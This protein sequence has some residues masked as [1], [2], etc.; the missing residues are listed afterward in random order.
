MNTLCSVFTKKTK[1]LLTSENNKIHFI[2]LNPPLLPQL[3]FLYRNFVGWVRGFLK[4]PCPL[5]H[6]LVKKKVT[7]GDTRQ[8]K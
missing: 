6:E 5:N 8:S 7:L 2:L 3:Q 1:E 4:N